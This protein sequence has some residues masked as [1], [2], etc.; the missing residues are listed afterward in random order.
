MWLS[1]SYVLIYECVYIFILNLLLKIPLLNDH[2]YSLCVNGHKIPRCSLSLIQCNEV[3]Y[4]IC[5]QCGVL[6]HSLSVEECGKICVFCNGILKV[7]EEVVRLSNDEE[8]K[9]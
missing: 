8:F 3:P 5:G 7:D 2:Y 1:L 6:A 9:T 4:F